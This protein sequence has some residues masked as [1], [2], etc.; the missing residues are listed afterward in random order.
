MATCP[1][2]GERIKRNEKPLAEHVMF[3]KHVIGALLMNESALAQAFGRDHPDVVETG[4]LARNGAAMA[5]A[6]HE[7]AHGRPAIDYGGPTVYEELYVFSAEQ[8]IAIKAEYPEAFERSRAAA[9]ADVADAKA[10]RMVAGIKVGADGVA[11]FDEEG[12]GERGDER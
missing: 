8:S 4:R 10:A 1:S 6:L 3:M 9:I 11:I 5:H 7:A 12:E 2:C